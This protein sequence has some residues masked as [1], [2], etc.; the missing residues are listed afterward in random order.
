[1]DSLISQGINLAMFG[2]GTVFVFLTLLIF[3]THLMSY[4]IN[5]FWIEN[6]D[7]AISST[8]NELNSPLAGPSR[9][10]VAIITA[11]VREHRRTRLA[12]PQIKKKLN[13]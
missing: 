12:P 9:Q 6:S 10:T 5:R 4:L 11:V 2:M 7:S 8:P 1:M 13:S 3:A